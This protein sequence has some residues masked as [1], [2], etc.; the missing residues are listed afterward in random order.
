MA[1]ATSA[2]TELGEDMFRVLPPASPPPFVVSSFRGC[3]AMMCMSLS[4]GV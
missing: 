4:F 3:V 2:R 1:S